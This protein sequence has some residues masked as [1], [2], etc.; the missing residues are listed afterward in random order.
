[1]E[2]LEIGWDEFSKKDGG[3][4]CPWDLKVIFLGPFD[5]VGAAVT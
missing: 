4:E 5:G 2:V 1:M 3:Y